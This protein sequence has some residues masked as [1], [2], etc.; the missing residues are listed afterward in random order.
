ML[1]N[2]DLDEKLSLEKHVEKLFNKVGVGIGAMRRI[3]LYVLPATLQTN[4]KTLVQ[5]CFDYCSPLWTNAVNKT[6]KT[7]NS[8]N[9]RQ[10][11]SQKPVTMLDPLIYSTP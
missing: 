10:G 6:G 1:G 4:S 8:K 7:P 3:K 9:M 11:L 5:L 2:I